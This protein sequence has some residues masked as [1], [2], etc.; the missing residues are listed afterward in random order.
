MY[1]V[2][3]AKVTFEGDRYY[4]LFR[5][6][7]TERESGARVGFWCL[8]FFLDFSLLGFLFQEERQSE[9]IRF[10]SGVSIDTLLVRERKKRERRRFLSFFGSRLCQRLKKSLRKVAWIK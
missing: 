1:V 2:S 7:E 9:I 10:H 3:G 5:V 8:I 4:R 6:G